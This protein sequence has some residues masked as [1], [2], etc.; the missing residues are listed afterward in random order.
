LHKRIET[1]RETGDT[2]SRRGRNSR[3]ALKRCQGVVELDY[4]RKLRNDAGEQQAD[5][6]RAKAGQKKI[7]KKRTLK[8]GGIS[9]LK[10][11]E[12]KG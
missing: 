4:S 8:G 5:S 7:I 10:L 2:P 1:K 6:G 11:R 12:R 3:G 9:A